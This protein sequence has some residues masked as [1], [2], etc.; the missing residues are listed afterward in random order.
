MAGE[1]DA[2]ITYLENDKSVQNLGLHV[3]SALSAEQ[4]MHENMASSAPMSVTFQQTIAFFTQINFL[5]GFV[6]PPPT[7]FPKE[8]S[9][10]QK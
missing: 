3:F 4:A 5:W 8:Q 6:T 1:G 2:A 9:F 7:P 10:V